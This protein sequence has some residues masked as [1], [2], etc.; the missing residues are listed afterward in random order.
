[1]DDFFQQLHAKIRDE[2]SEITT[3]FRKIKA[4]KIGQ[5]TKNADALN[6]LSAEIEALF[7]EISNI[8]TSIKC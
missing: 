3:E 8:E 4:E 7:N 5:S 1:M 2:E 6:A